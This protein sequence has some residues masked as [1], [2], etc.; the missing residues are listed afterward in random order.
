MAK[1]TRS[2]T[3]KFAD[4]ES[5]KLRS[6]AADAGLKSRRLFGGKLSEIPRVFHAR[7]V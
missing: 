2:V 5:S 6:R 7:D 4:H 3:T 1:L